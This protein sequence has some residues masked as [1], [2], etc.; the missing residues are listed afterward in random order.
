[1]ELT[2]LSLDHWIFILYIYIYINL[3]RTATRIRLSGKYS[4]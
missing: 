4:E 3:Y 2:V 1:M